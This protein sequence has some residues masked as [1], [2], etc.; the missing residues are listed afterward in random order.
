MGTTFLEVVSPERGDATAARFLERRGG[1][2]GYMVILQVDD[3]ATSRR[4]LMERGVRVVWAIDLDDIS[5]I[6]LHPRDLGGAIVSIDQP[7]PPEAWRWA[8]PDWQSLSTA[9]G[10]V[11]RIDGVE[12]A[13]RDPEAMA[14]RW[15]AAIGGTALDRP[16]GGSRIALTPGSLDFVPVCDD[17]GEGVVAVRMVA[18]RAD[19][20]RRRARGRGLVDAAGAIVVAGTRFDLS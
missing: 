13:A 6:H 1:D 17:R 10:L 11:T 5:T 3:L 20:V 16:G 9:G 4:R 14:T 12:V 18:P 7:R 8:G 15:A 2:S 19:E